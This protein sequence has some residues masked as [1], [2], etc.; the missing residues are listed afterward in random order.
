MD[1]FQR[2]DQAR[3]NTKWLVVCFALAVAGI[4]LSVYLAATLVFAG[5]KAKQHR[6]V[7]YDSNQPQL[8]L[9]NP[10]LF[11]GVAMG[12]LAVIG[13]GSAYKISALSAGGSTVAESLGGRLV[14]S[15]TTDPDERKL[16]NV[17]EEMSIAS[18]TPMP[19]V[20]VLD[21]E[22]GINAFAAGHTTSDA[23]VTVTRG[24]LRSLKRDELQGVIGHEFSHILNGDMKLNLRLMGIL[25]G[26]VSLV[27]IG[28]ILTN[29]RGGSREKNNAL[30]LFGLALIVIGAIGA[31]F[32]NLI[33]A[34]VSRQREFLADASSVQF[35]RN[36][37]GLS[38]ALQ[39]IGSAGSELESAH[40]QEASHMFFANGLKSSFFSAFA[41]HPPLEERIKAI[42]PAWDGKFQAIKPFTETEPPKKSATQP[43]SPFPPILGMP[44]L[45][46]LAAAAVLPN[47]G[48]PTP[49]HLRYAEQFRD[50]I[51]DDI[52]LATRE[53]LAAAAL[54]Y[55]LL[56]DEDASLRRTQ[57]DELT[58]RF[59]AVQ[60]KVV[61][62]APAVTSLATH[63]RLP[64]VNLALPAL[65]QLTTA[66]FKT[67]SDTLKWLI[68]S[69]GEV[70]LFEFTL[71]KIIRRHLA[72]QF[73][74]TRRDVVQFYSI[75]PLVPDCAV[76]L[77][78]L[79]HVG[80]GDAAQQQRAFVAGAPYLRA[81]DGLGFYPPEN[82][83]LAE[84]DA[85]LNRLAQAAPQIKKNLLEASVRVVGA[86]GVV[87]EHEAELL[88]AVA[89]TL[90][91][92]IPPFV[93]TV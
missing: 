82:C 10:Q 8:T 30:P 66:D 58:R 61:A 34:A 54:I 60:P 14:S 50:A 3:K 55:A 49:L 5:V 18:G 41:T 68:E 63:A 11:A 72:S 24:C 74:E 25:F 6:Y 71:Q 75:K 44:Q 81:T 29:V 69:D 87:Q 86:D 9:W 93:T 43:R 52:K 1:F 76:L 47:L 17:V 73:G 4:V 88:R 79:A 80:S 53:P 92:P 7:D 84:I 27:T 62:L 28:R 48:Q 89:D 78:A 56:L 35:T 77:S 83:S 37:S 85:A 36:P 26:I 21:A 16:L 46:G 57:L 91:C 12:V 13:L 33:Q 64:L 15:N 20:F 2:Q 70:D 90:D 45:A 65:R 67:F 40:A 39:K 22:S 59:P 51:P 31:F 23:A 32:A 38:V 19:Q 42:D